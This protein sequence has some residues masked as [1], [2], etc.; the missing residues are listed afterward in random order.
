MKALEKR[1][2]AL[3]RQL[4]QYP[5]LESRDNP[6]LQYFG[7]LSGRHP[8]SPTND[9]MEAWLQLSFPGKWTTSVDGIALVPAYYPAFSPEGNY[10][11][12]KRFKIDVFSHQEPNLPVTVVDW[13]TADFPDPGLHPVFFSFPQSDV[14]SVRITVTKG[15]RQADSQ[16]FALD[17]WMV[18]QNGN[19]I[20]PPAY[21][22]LEASDSYNEAPYWKLPYLTD[23]K[24]QVGRN[25]HTVH[26]VP[27]FIQYYDEQTIRD[28]PPEIEIDLGAQHNIGRVE[29][30][31][32]KVPDMPIP[33]FAFP[34]KYHIELRRALNEN[35][36]VQSAVIEE[37]LPSRMRW[38]PLSAVRARFLR[39]TLHAL[40]RHN[41]RPVFAM[42]EIRVI[43]RE[44]DQQENLAAG[45][46]IRMTRLPEDAGTAPALLVD[47][48]GNGRE[49]IQEH[50]HIEQLAERKKV[51]EALAQTQ[52][53]L[54][55]ARATRQSFYWTIGI[56]GG[57]VLLF[58][59]ILW[60][61]Y[62]RTI[63]QRALYELRQQIAADLHDD[64]SSNLGTISMIAKR[65]QQDPPPSLLQE[66]LNEIGHIAQESF[67]SIKEIIW[68]MDS[69]VVHLAEMFGHIEKTARSI[70]AGSQV[71]CEF[72]DNV[73]EAAVPA[74]TRR[75]IMLLVKEA[76]YNCAKYAKAEHMRIHADLRHCV[77]VLSM[78]D[79]GCG[80]DP[81]CAQVANSDTGR[82]L[83]NME[84]RARLLGAELDIFSEP[85]K[86][87]E[88]TLSMPI[89]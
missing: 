37:T 63:R 35:P 68:H 25:L 5:P 38:H 70:L 79:D 81:A 49:I 43:G 85:G 30:Y 1:E 23:R 83:A 61:A 88:V 67:L 69:D 31:P 9:T 29:L 78:K 58:S 20:A 33:E 62:Q 6:P 7:Y 32:A 4:E 21:Q 44:G 51:A 19:N 17:E 3:K 10:G 60:I 65:L 22:R 56:G 76:L 13:T 16:F 72:P 74:K 50:D 41:D 15:E 53:R 39:L 86:G 87:T 14:Q 80:F 46:T 89:K 26:P 52:H 2:Q 55:I 18:F 75:N 28:H 27:D 54:L 11:F 34:L 84:R 57:I 82:G 45:K 64:I 59:L 42:A 8:V 77:L 36:I 66:K 48:F 71:I 24:L 12:P 47:G 73:A 40:P